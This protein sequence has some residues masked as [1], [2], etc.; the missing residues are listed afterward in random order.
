MP[1]AGKPGRCNAEKESHMI[2]T[3]TRRTLRLTDVEYIAGTGWLTEPLVRPFPRG[4]RQGRSEG[5]RRP[6]RRCCRT[7][8]THRLRSSPGT[9]RLGSCSV[10]DV[11]APTWLCSPNSTTPTSS[12]PGMAGSSSLL[13][14]VPTRPNRSTRCGGN[15]G[16][17]H[18]PCQPHV[19]SCPDGCRADRH[20]L[21]RVP[22]RHDHPGS[23][24][25]W[26]NTPDQAKEPA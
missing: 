1:H 17:R 12:T 6:R 18:R 5:Q 25:G 19:T 24:A 23:F 10:R 9:A 13:A 22:H 8:G 14:T 20:W 16:L 21:H 11:T 3:V 15:R 7:K 26:A 2:G 4:D